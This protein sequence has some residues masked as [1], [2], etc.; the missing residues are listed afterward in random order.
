[1]VDGCLSF[2]IELHEQNEYWPS[3]GSASSSIESRIPEKEV[4]CQ[5]HG[6]SLFSCARSPAALL[7]FFIALAVAGDDKRH[8][9]MGWIAFVVSEISGGRTYSELIRMP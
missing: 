6:A 9:V 2:A 3:I 7:S 1:L 5:I 8:P 4:S